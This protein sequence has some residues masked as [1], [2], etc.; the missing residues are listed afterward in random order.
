MLKIY[1]WALVTGLCLLIARPS[2]HAQRSAAG[3]TT[4]VAP[5]T[6][7][8]TGGSQ[9]A[10]RNPEQTPWSYLIDSLTANLDKSPITSDILYDRALPLAALHSFGTRRADTTSSAHLRQAYLEL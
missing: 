6:G 2:A 10:D 7:G 5:G 3:G 1:F 8:G 4:K 9:P